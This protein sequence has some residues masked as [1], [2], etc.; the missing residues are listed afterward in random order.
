MT[1][2]ASEL[3]INLLAPAGDKAAVRAT[4]REH[5]IVVVQQ[6]LD[7]RFLDDALGTLRKLLGVRLESV[8]H[9]PQPDADADQLIEE[10][11]RLDPGYVMDV[12]RVA[13][14]TPEFYATFT[15]PR[16]K[17]IAQALLS[18]DI[19]QCVHDSAQVRI[20]PPDYTVR[21]FDWHQDFHYN[22]TSEDALTA[23][24]PLTPVT[25]DMGPLVVVPGPDQALSRVT[26]DRSQHTSG[27][28]T[29]HSTL[30]FLVD[31]KEYESKGI[32]LDIMEPGD[33]AFFNCRVMHRSGMNRS[34]RSRIVLNPRYS[35]AL[36]TTIA[37]RGWKVMRDKT[38]DVF[39]KLY[40]ELLA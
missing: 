2:L 25:V 10:L 15:D 28:G 22:V 6:L 32:A 18:A 30:R 16:I 21:N 27:A 39:E 35:N 38:P 4:Y 14:E 19:I 5:G 17:S 1:A 37:G 26:L 13:K 29:A 33:V 12:I 7:A 31:A 11:G 3:D 34:S 8:G 36:E 20:D 9:S 24:I 23:W 40:P